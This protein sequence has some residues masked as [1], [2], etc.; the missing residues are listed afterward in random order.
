MANNLDKLFSEAASLYRDGFAPRTLV[1][2]LK[3]S[4][5]DA[6]YTKLKLDGYNFSLE[7]SEKDILKVIHALDEE[8]ERFTR[9]NDLFSLE[10][11][12]IKA[13]NSL[14]DNEPGAGAVVIT[15]GNPVEPTANVSGSNASSNAIP[16]FNPNDRSAP[17]QG[18]QNSTSQGNAQNTPQPAQQNT[19]PT[20]QTGKAVSWNDVKKRANA[21]LK[22]FLMPGKARIEGSIVTID[23]LEARHKFH[24]DQLKSRRDELRELVDDVLGKG[25]TIQLNGEGG[26]LTLKPDAAD[27]VGGSAAGASPQ[28]IQEKPQPAIESNSVSTSETTESEPETNNSDSENTETEETPLITT[29]NSDAP[30]PVKNKSEVEEVKPAKRSIKAPDTIPD[31]DFFDAK[32]IQK[33]EKKKL[34]AIPENDTIKVD[35]LD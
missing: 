15:Q 6:V 2:R 9:H 7:N 29:V 4:L 3:M 30:K 32:K 23:F 24:F 1:E 33:A 21:Q 31:D 26:N 11:A 17:A 16:D 27:T 12:L 28:I 34:A 14:S 5:R 10:V 35:D 19:A 25:Y 8:N 18:V 22:A 13:H 20:A